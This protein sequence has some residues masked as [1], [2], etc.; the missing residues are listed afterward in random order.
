MTATP[1]TEPVFYAD[2]YRRE[3]EVWVDALVQD[4]RFGTC[5][6]LSATLCHPHGGGQKGDRATLLLSDDAAAAL[7]APE[8]LAIAD[9]RKADG[10][11]LHVLGG[12][13]EPERVEAAL[14]G[15]QPFRLRL[16]WAFRQR[17]M[18]LHSAAHLLHCFVERVLGRAVDHPETSDLQPDFG[19]NRYERADLLAPAQLEAVLHQLNAFTAAGHAITTVPDPH[20]AGFRTWHCA[21]WTIPCGGTH[22]ADTREIGPVRA[23]LSLKRGRTSLTFRVSEQAP[24]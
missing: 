5:L 15:T 19:L 8:G 21:E 14:V 17:Q 10:R 22:P 12:A 23:D 7:D 20:R 1:E 13:V 4:A 11:I 9:T 3:L 16:D 24:G 2:V 18:R 6:V